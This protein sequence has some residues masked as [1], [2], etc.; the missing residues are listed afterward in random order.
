MTDGE[1][2]AK[3]LKVERTK[4]KA[5]LGRK[6]GY[7][8]RMATTMIEEELRKE[9]KEVEEA[10]KKVT[11]ANDEY[12]LQLVLNADGDE[13]QK[14]R[15]YTPLGGNG[16]LRLP[17]KVR[18][19]EYEQLKTAKNKLKRQRE[20]EFTRRQKA[21]ENE[22]TAAE[23][24]RAKFAMVQLKEAEAQRAK[25][26]ETQIAA[27]EAPIE[28]IKAQHKAVEEG[29]TASVTGTR[30]GGSPTGA[31]SKIRLKPTS[32]PKFNGSMRD[33]YCWEKD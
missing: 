25:L 16:L 10:V 30:A 29:H 26:A 7:V 1:E 28:L 22:R 6:V 21:A 13:D 12:S 4:A 5:A 15:R 27:E 11:E 32:L 14:R 9:Y 24:E 2:T 8:S 19:G 23:D 17:R 3:Q 18:R 20:A 33:F 31:I